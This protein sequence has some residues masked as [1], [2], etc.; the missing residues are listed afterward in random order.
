MKVWHCSRTDGR[1]KLYNPAFARMWSL[2]P[3][4]LDEQPHVD[5]VI[6][7]ARPLFGDA[8]MWEELKYAVTSFDTGREPLNER[9][10]R[11]D[12]MVLQAATVPLPDGNTLLTYADVTASTRM[13]NA[14]RER[15]EALEAAD[16][17]KTNFLSNVSYE[18]RTP[19]T[20]IIGFSREPVD[21]HRR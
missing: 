4:F 10:A 5:Q 16:R 14:L 2:A 19:L 11:P 7:R 9:I 21:R 12:G 13:E 8:A 3:E 18:L 1:L 6:E 20:N 15:A 17:L